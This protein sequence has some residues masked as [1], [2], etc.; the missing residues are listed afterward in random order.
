MMHS[1]QSIL[2]QANEF[3][4]ISIVYIFSHSQI[5]KAT[6]YIIYTYQKVPRILIIAQLCHFEPDFTGE[7][8]KLYILQ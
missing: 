7:K 1:D 3:R 2:Y 6:S 4:N 8:S 5:F